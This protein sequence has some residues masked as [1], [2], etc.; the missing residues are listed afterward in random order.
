MYLK[1]IIK[2]FWYSESWLASIGFINR[3]VQTF[4]GYICFILFT[5]PI[6]KFGLCPYL[7]SNQVILYIFQY[8]DSFCAMYDYDGGSNT[9]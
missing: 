9:R 5:H 3:N 6:E 1:A 4:T 8:I 2:N 7:I